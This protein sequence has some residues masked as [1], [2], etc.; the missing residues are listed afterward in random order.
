[1]VRV[2][3]ASPGK[4]ELCPG[5]DF[6]RPGNLLLPVCRF[7]V[8]R[9]DFF[10]FVCSHHLIEDDIGIDLKAC[11][12]KCADSSQ[13]LVKGPVFCTDASLLIKFSK[14]VHVINVVADGS[15][16]GSTLVGRREPD[17][18][19]AGVFQ[20]GCAGFCFLPES[21]VRGE[22]PFKKLNN[23]LIFHIIKPPFEDFRNLTA[24]EGRLST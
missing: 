16:A 17:R 24:M 9:R 13:I 11:G 19:N 23:R 10:G 20:V 15:R 8:D 2:L 22:I 7:C 21:P 5:F 6:V 1:M 4:C 14:I 12:M 3:A 18:G